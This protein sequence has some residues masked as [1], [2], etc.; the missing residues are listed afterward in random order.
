MITAIT[1]TFNAD[2]DI[3]ITSPAGT[4]V[5]L[6]SDNGGANDN[7]Y[8]GTTWDDDANPLGQV[9]YTTN[10]GLASD[11]SYINLTAATPLAPEEAFGAFIGENPNG[12]WT[13]RVSDDLG[14]DV[15]SINS[16]SLVI[17]GLTAAPT[18]ATT[19][20]TNT[21][22]LAIPAGPAVVSSNIIVSG[23]GTQL[24]DV[25]LTTFLT[26]TFASDLD[27]TLRSPSGTVVTLT[28]DNGAGND[29]VFNG[30]I[31]DD[32]ANPG[33]QVP[34]ATNNGMAT[35]HSYVNLTTASP[36]APEE[37]L[38]AFIGENPNGTWTLTIS[39]DLGGDGGNLASW[40]LN[41][42]TSICSGFCVGTPRTFTI[43]VNPN[44]AIVIVADPGTTLCE[45][46][47]TLLTVVT[48]TATP[49]GTLYTQTGAAGASPNSQAFEPA[50][51]AFNNQAAEDFVVPAGANWSI[52]QVSANGL[53]FNGAGPSTS[54]N[55]FFYNNA[56]GIPGSVIASYTNLAY[57]GGASPVITIPATNLSAG[58]Y[59]VSIQSN[60]SFAA[61]GQWA[62]GA[63]GATATGSPWAW[64]NPGGGFAVCPTWGNGAVTC[65]PGTARNLLFTLT[66]TSVAGGGPLGPG[67]TFLWTPAAGLS[68][69]T[70]NPV[71]ASPMNTTT[72]TVTAYNTGWLYKTGFM[73]PLQLTSVL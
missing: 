25:N 28:T 3:T 29:N 11:H 53:Y 55:V 43:T 58:T 7:V 48:G 5:T 51:V 6:T 41:M 2:L 16:W 49:V 36:L 19:S 68:S 66:G 37:A 8:N 22:P 61:G 52:T 71:A 60:M 59:W 10:N 32:D 57:T 42:Q 14:G 24:L 67:Y 56:G 50:N 73:L 70:S 31:W 54:F 45:G 47:P 64:Q 1:H 69:T 63:S 40:T 4:V 46:D 33:G 20:A 39:D 17:S 30:T 15:G 23:A 65:V 35:D 12:T 44:P 72:Y 18:V 21:T 13:L 27:I 62:W 34:Y 26:H 9:P 38:A